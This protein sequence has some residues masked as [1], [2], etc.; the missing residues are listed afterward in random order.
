MGRPKK[1]D[2]TS[3]MIKEAIDEPVKEL[4]VSSL[5]DN[6]VIST[7]STLLDLEIS[8]NRISGGG[9]PGG[10]VGAVAWAARR[11][12]DSRMQA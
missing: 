7:G 3:E 10:H 1:I 12:P 2:K 4:N 8:G 11:R 5:Y 9:L 6:G